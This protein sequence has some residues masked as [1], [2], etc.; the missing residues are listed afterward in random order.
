MVF[1]L[2]ELARRMLADFDARTPG[3]SVGESF[4]LT[5]GQAYALQTEVA[6]LR[7]ERGEQVIG[8]KVGCTSTVI[9]AQLGV[10]EPIFGRLFDTGC[11]PSGAH[12]SSACF[13][14][15]SVEG[16]LAVRLGDDL[17]GVTVSEEACRQAIEA[18]F[19]VIELHH[20]VLPAVWPRAQWLIASGGM[21]AGFVYAKTET[22]SP[23]L[24]K[25]ARSLSVRINE[26]EVGSVADA[27][28]LAFPSASLRWLVGR[29]AEFGLQLF[30]GQVILTGSP[31][32]LFPIAP[33]DR[34]VVEVPPLGAS[35]VQIDP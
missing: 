17:A 26:V 25:I 10:R 14:N 24:A 7:E 13:A 11:H 19:P 4:D 12:L 35:C 3:Q 30:K 1:D 29:L 16:E 8:Y 18:V 2:Q 22:T 32:K 20:Y 5:I 9:Q 33:R 15:L 21:H 34:I 23:G 6:R 28:S 27:M 31:M